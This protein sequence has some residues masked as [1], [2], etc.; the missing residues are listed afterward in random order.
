MWF[1]V[2]LPKPALLT[3]LQFES[4]AGVYEITRG[5][6]LNSDAPPVGTRARR[7]W[8]RCG[9]SAATGPQLRVPRAY[10]VEV[11]ADGKT[12]KTIAEGKDTWH[13]VHGI[14]SSGTGNQG[15]S[16]ATTTV[17]FQPVDAKFVR[18]TQTGTEENAPVWSIQSLQLYTPGGRN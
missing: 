18:I 13:D 14:P 11:S 17:S 15:E 12:W 5:R 6:I 1:Q 7:R 9:R 4:T 16:A 3:E 2:E 8:G 10:K